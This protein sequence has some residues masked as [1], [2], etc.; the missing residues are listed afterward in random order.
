LSSADATANAM[1]AQQNVTAVPAVYEDMV[2][3]IM[4][5]CAETRQR[6]ATTITKIQ[7]RSHDDHEDAADEA[8]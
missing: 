5:R 2:A 7:P 6:S 4:R 1:A 8:T 3:A